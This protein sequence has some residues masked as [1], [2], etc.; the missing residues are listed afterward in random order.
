MQN[1]E[2]K[3]DF[4]LNLIPFIGFMSVCICFLLLTAVWIEIAS[5]NVKQA[6]GG[7]SAAETE[8]KPLL[9]VMMDIDGALSLDV[10]DA[11]KVPAALRKLRIA[12]K[13]GKV[14][15][16]EVEKVAAN[17]L[18]VE[19]NLSTALIQPKAQS[20]YEDIISLMDSFKKNGLHDL[21]VAP[22]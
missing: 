18:A 15:L 4:E 5:I 21:G 22:L 8:K 9:W 19:P 20:S 11:A 1:K 12:S 14:D 6:V 10:R 2:K 3:Y 13:D 7:Q 16:A 17:L